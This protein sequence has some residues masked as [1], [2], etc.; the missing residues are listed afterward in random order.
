MKKLLHFIISKTFIIN[1]VLSFAL[2]ILV[3]GFTYKWLNSYTRH[4]TS[5]SVPDLR[6]MQVDELKEFLKFKSLDYKVADSTLY[7]L[8]HAPGT[9]LD[10]EP[11]PEAKVKEDRTIYVTI[12]RTTPPKVS[13]PD[14]MDNSLRQA[15]LIL[16][17]YGLEVGELIYKPDLAKNAVLEIQLNGRSIEPGTEVTKGTVVD[18]VLGDG[19]GNTK[20]PVPDLFNLTVDEAMFVIRA[21]SLNIGNL[22]YD[23]SVMDSSKA[24][25]YRQRP[26]FEEGRVINQGESLDLYLTESDDVIRTFSLDESANG[27]E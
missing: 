15:E 12:T 13:V 4:G 7:S 1:L 25:V 17:S 3:F 26:Y 9:V 16:K 2:V 21:S 24:R 14:L 10:Q 23:S 8:D 11:L 27:E 20:V 6:G 19:F 5:V 18:L 22:I